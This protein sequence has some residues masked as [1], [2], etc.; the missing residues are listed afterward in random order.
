MRLVLALLLVL[1]MSGCKLELYAS[2]TERQGNQVLALL[3]NHGIDAS[4]VQGK[5][6]EVSI[7]VDKADVAA[8]VDLLDRHGLP[9]DQFTNLGTVFQQKG[10]VSSPL[11]E[12]VRYSYG[13]S[14]S[15]AE[16][17]TQ[18]DGVLTARVHVVLPEPKTTEQ[19]AE[20]A[21]AAVFLRYRDGAAIEDDVP[22]IK[23]LVQNSI[24]GLSYEKISVAM[25]AADE[26]PARQQSGP[27]MA[28]LLGVRVAKDSLL[29]LAA[30]LFVLVAALIAAVAALV[31]QL[32]RARAA[33]ARPGARPGAAADAAR[34]AAGDGR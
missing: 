26:P 2:L 23:Q 19:S 6:G 13:L 24:E 27:P 32:R 31:L 10:L 25:F 11:E 21:S 12:R 8:A 22:Q 16:T 3:L 18:I 34:A 33:G 28:D 14:Q 7:Q 15:I 29:P 1:G 5:G 17:L 9:Q 30:G 20:P 4:K